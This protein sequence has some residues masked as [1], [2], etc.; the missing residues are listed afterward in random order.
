MKGSYLVC[1]VTGLFFSCVWLCPAG[2]VS[3]VIC[4]DYDIYFAD[5]GGFGDY[6]TSSGDV[7][8]R[9]PYVEVI[10]NYDQST[11]WDG[12]TTHNTPVG[13]TPTLSLSPIGMGYKILVHLKAS[14]HQDNIII[15]RD[16]QIGW[17]DHIFEVDDNFKP[18]KVGGT[19]QLALRDDDFPG[20]WQEYFNLA[21]APG[22][23]IDR[24]TGDVDDVTHYMY[25]SCGIC[26]SPCTVG[27]SSWMCDNWDRKYSI[28]HEVGHQMQH[29]ANSGIVANYTYAGDGNC[30]F[31]NPSWSAISKEFQTAAAFEGFAEFYNATVW[32]MG[33]ESDC[34]NP[35]DHDQFDNDCEGGDS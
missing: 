17:T 9:G 26:A 25:A 31:A 5:D 12:Y 35:W 14:V 23:A 6:W 15:V 19:Y 1:I 24:R 28:I 34:E 29:F 20:D 10:K 30:E 16:Q 18:T 2:A 13:C 22:F 33:G 8:A 11:V 21:A 4:I 27:G 3:T 32:N 7:D